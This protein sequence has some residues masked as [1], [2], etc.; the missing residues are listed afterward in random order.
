LSPV[1]IDVLCGVVTII[2]TPRKSMTDSRYKFFKRFLSIIFIVEL[3]VALAVA[4]IQLL[5]TY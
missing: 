2:V 5:K 3:E 1:G 4:F